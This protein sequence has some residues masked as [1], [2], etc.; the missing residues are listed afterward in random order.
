MRNIAKERQ[1]YYARNERAIIA[2]SAIGH[3]QRVEPPADVERREF[4]GP[5]GFCGTSALYSCRHRRIPESQRES[6]PA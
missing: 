4:S 1:R 6:Q 3:V 5:C 2:R